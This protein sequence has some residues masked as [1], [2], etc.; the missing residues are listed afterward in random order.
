VSGGLNR[1]GSS[2]TLPRYSSNGKKRPDGSIA[3][4]VT[5]MIT[6][7]LC[8]YINETVLTKVTLACGMARTKH[9]LS[10]TTP[11][12][13]VTASSFPMC[14]A[15]SRVT[16]GSLPGEVAQGRSCDLASCWGCCLE[17]LPSLIDRAVTLFDP[18]FAQIHSSP[19]EPE[20]PFRLS[21]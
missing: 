3:S 8:R 6:K 19:E 9:T 21:S 12:W 17:H 11:I 15:F 18:S 2:W 5:I 4:E 14:I 16:R 20:S 13:T 10:S 1:H 7:L